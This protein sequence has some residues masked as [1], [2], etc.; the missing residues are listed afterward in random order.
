MSTVPEVIA[1]RQHGLSVLAISVVTNMSVSST[2]D[3]RITTEQ[4]V[5]DTMVAIKPK[6]RILVS[7]ILGAV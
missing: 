3:H 5:W 7:G 4:D 1:A 6:F 2:E